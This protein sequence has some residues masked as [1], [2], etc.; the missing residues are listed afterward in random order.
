MGRPAKGL[1]LADLVPVQVGTAYARTAL[2]DLQRWAPRLEPA[3]RLRVGTE[4]QLSALA[5]DVAACVR[6]AQSG[7]WL[8]RTNPTAALE[9]V[10]ELAG[11]WAYLVPEGDPD[12]VRLGLEA[13]HVRAWVEMGAAVTVAQ[14]AQL[15]SVTARTVQGALKGELL[16]GAPGGGVLGSDAR[17]WLASRCVSLE[18]VRKLG[19]WPYLYQCGGGQAWLLIPPG[20]FLADPLGEREGWDR[21]D[22]GAWVTPVRTVG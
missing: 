17:A 20:G 3:A 1:R 12:G 4:V 13:C 16:E 19:E 11:R 22:G 18:A 9:V 7:L 8:G 5:A 21:I 15:A 10:G 2:E 6:Y 14:L